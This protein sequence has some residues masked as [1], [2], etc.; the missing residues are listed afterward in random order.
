LVVA[1]GQENGGLLDSITNL[2]SSI[3]G[4]NSN[5]ATLQGENGALQDSIAKLN[6]ANTTLQG[7]LTNCE[8]DGGLLVD[9]IVVLNGDIADLNGAITV[10]ETQIG[11]LNDSI[12]ALWQEITDLSQQLE[13]CGQGS[14]NAQLIPENHINIHP[15]PVNYELQITNYDF[16]QGDVVELFDMMGK[17]VYAARVNSAM[18]TFTIDMSAFPSGNYL[19]RIGDRAAKIVKQ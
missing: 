8:T 9:S 1:L 16:H 3:D 14:S 12:T 5:V 17:C 7:L 11:T 6:A 19:L 13:D 15:N 10:L 18:N 2:N 4:L